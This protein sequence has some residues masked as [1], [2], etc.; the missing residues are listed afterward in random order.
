MTRPPARW[1]AALRRRSGDNAERGE[2][3]SASER[4]AFLARFAPFGDLAD[5][6]LARVAAAVEVRAYPRGVDVL[7]ESGAPATAFYVIRSGSMELVHEG[8]VVD[9]L[10]PGEG[11]GHPSLLTGFGAA[12]TVRAHEDSICY[13][14]P[15]ELALDVLGRVSGARFVATTL[16]E[17]L[18]RTGDTVHALPDIAGARVSSLLGRPA[19]FCDAEASIRSVA[20]EMTDRDVT[21]ILVRTAGGLGIVTDADIRRR[22]AAEGVAIDAPVGDVATTPVVTVS[23]GSLA[24]D[25]LL[26][27]L[28]ADVHHLPVVDARGEVTRIVSGDDLM[29]LESRSPFALRRL[30]A[31][32]P[33]VD[34]L[35]G[36]AAHLRDLLAVLVDAGLS[37][38]DVS[39][40]LALQSDT[41]T[42]RLVDLAVAAHGEPPVPWAWLALGSVARREVTL[43]SDQDNALA[44]AGEGH[45]PVADEY[46]ER[47]GRFV[48]DGLAR[49]GFGHDEIGVLAGDRRWRMSE[50]E[51]RAVFRDC[52]AFP[53]R[54]HLLR[55]AVA[56]DFRHVAGGLEI[57]TPLVQILQHARD[58]REFLA[59][60]ARTAIDYR[61]PLGF[62]G[63]IAAGRGRSGGTIDLKAGAI[64]PIANIARFYALANG[65]TVSSTLPRLVAAEDVGALDRTT[66]QS[67]REAFAIVSRVR[68]GSHAAQIQAGRRPD[69]LL[70][71]GELPPL[72]R[73]ELREALR[74]IASAQKHLRR[75]VDLGL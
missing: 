64:T 27:M 35:A 42:T 44:Y 53:S 32:A 43:A 31:H 68:L 8:Q 60:L 39:R 22:V 9:V 61:P 67:L 18:T 21:A 37:A 71:P 36:A 65:I 49:C 40:V 5:D 75:I 1:S 28:E 33:D 41:A 63:H 2:A 56:F 20:R 58:Y 72:A 6:E 73:T 19:V 57:A 17:R 23:D 29:N 55:A 70:D 74:A 62:R 50:G 3:T 52:L 59:V 34:A 47:F 12:F 66:A 38:A 24:M 4:R 30:L 25:A 51:W 69:N 11:F 15:R 26:D 10:T 14:I 7:V 13:L 48:N 54:S 45:D 46:F 16:R